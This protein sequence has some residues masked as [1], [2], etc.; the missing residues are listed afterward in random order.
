[1]V[2]N[3]KS[4][5]IPIIP[6]FG[7]HHGLLH[8]FFLLLFVQAIR[9][10]SLSANLNVDDCRCNLIMISKTSNHSCSL[11]IIITDLSHETHPGYPQ[12]MESAST[13]LLACSHHG[14]LLVTAQARVHDLQGLPAWVDA[15][16]EIR[17]NHWCSMIMM[18]WFWICFDLCLR[19]C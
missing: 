7:R 4:W 15:V 14:K 16:E 2:F 1:M 9:A 18:H 6:T 19:H 3:G 8:W 17:L 13:G 11:L 5:F 10:S 12:M